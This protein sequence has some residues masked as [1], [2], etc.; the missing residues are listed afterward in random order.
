MKSFVTSFDF[1]FFDIKLLDA[2]K[3]LEYICVD[4]S[5]I[6]E[7]LKKLAAIMSEKII[8]TIPLIGGVN[9]ET[10]FREE[11]VS[12]MSQL[13]LKRVKIHPYHELAVGKYEKLG[14]KY[15]FRSSKEI[16]THSFS[17]AL[18]KNAFVIVE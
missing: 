6:L 8:L 4:N 11:L 3:H 5:L 12:L 7:N 16:D 17:E 10:S 9:D 1:I 18:K 15:A 2:E 13:N 14:R